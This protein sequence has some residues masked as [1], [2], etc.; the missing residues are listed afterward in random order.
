MTSISYEGGTRTQYSSLEAWN[1]REDDFPKSGSLSEKINFFLRYAILAP[2]GHN[3]Q[4]WLFKI[5]GNNAI[6]IHADRSR[7]LPVVDPDDRELIISCG[8]TLYHLRL[9]ANHF[10]IVDE[11]RLLADKNNPDLAR[12]SLKDDDEGTIKKQAKR[13]APLFEANTKRRSNRSSFENRRLPD[14][15]LA[16][17]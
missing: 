17:L 7:A 5:V 10:S 15:L 1:V 14:C 4:P 3:T 13:D 6:E 9:A 11:V 2:S 12:I 16:S 8:A